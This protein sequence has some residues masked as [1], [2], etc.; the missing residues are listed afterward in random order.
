[1]NKP[2]LKV[3]AVGA[4]QTRLDRHAAWWR[5][6]R[7][8]ARVTFGMALR[9]FYAE[10]KRKPDLGTP[11]AVEGVPGARA[12]QMGTGHTLYFALVE[13]A[14]LRPYVLVFGVKGP[15]EERPYLAV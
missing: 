10:V 6:N 1:M 11:Y 12:V 7:K 9:E 3:V 13:Q 8:A 15:G 4:V 2:V 5:V 14:P